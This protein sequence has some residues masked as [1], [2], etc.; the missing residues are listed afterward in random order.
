MIGQPTT[1]P[2]NQ[3]PT[4]VPRAAA[5]VCPSTPVSAGKPP[6]PPPPSSGSAASRRLVRDKEE[7]GIAKG[8]WIPRTVLCVEGVGVWVCFRCGGEVVRGPEDSVCVMWRYG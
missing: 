8:Q 2:I 1:H 3:Q 6:S 5:I 7:E 4:Y